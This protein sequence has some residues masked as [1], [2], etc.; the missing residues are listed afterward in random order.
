MIGH[1]GMQRLI[2]IG[3]GARNIVVKLVRLWR[4]ALVDQPKRGITLA[5]IRH[6]H[7]QRTHVKQLVKV[8]PFDAHFVMDTVDMLGPA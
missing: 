7:A 6:D 5:F 1:H 3:L 2:A 4:P 8:E